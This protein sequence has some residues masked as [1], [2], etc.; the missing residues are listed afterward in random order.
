MTK[1]KL[2]K[3]L[4]QIIKDLKPY[5]PEKII[6]YGSCDRDDFEKDSDIGLLIIKKQIKIFLIG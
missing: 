2:Q 1:Q 5:K 3:N 4:N 6:L